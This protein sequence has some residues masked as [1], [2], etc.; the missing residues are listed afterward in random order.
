M[1]VR[2]PF[3]A[4]GVEECVVTYCYVAVGDRVKSA[5]D[6]IELQT[7]KAIF[8]VPSPVDGTV[9][10]LSVAAGDS[11]RVGEILCVIA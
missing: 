6:L 3:L 5:D 2:V 8:N 1:E 10:A 9:Q 4:E 11:V 7:S